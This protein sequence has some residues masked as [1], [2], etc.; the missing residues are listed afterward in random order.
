MH[1]GNFV[2]DG[3]L[4]PDRTPSPGLLEYQKVIEPVR[5]SRDGDRLRIA[6]RY[7]FLG[8]SHLNFTW[9]AEV[10]GEPVAAGSLDVPDAGPGESVTVP[11]PAVPPVGQDGGEVW[12][13][14]R[15]ALADW[16]PWAAAGHEVGWGQF[17]VGEAPPPARPPPPPARWR[18]RPGRSGS[19]RGSSIGRRNADQPG[20]D[21]RRRAPPRS[22]AGADRQ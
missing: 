14:V 11:L 13:T 5:I 12:L 20:L 19:A 2:A 9:S 4:F 22:V 21:G 10:D 17:R 6:N 15:A 18:S 1:D 7:D 3:L 8:L 16:R